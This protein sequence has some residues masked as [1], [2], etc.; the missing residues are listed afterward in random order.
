MTDEFDSSEAHQRL[1]IMCRSS[2]GFKIAEKDLEIR[3]PGEFLGT[4]QSGLPDFWFA[5]IVR[6]QKLLALSRKEAKEFLKIRG[7]TR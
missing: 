6:D 5:H 4:R 1:D 7:E 3:G 2:D